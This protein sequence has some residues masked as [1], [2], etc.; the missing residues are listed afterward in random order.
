MGFFK[1]QRKTITSRKMKI[2]NS[3]RFLYDLRQIDMYQIVA[4]SD[5]ANSA[6]EKWS[7]LLSLVIEKHSPL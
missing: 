2:F 5:N 3:D 6:V 4:T 7:H 1:R